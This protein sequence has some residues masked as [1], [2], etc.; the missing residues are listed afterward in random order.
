MKAFSIMA[1]AF[2]RWIDSV[3]QAVL[4][5]H[6]W[7]APPRVVQLIEG[8]TGTFAV[9]TDGQ[10]ADARSPNGCLRIAEGKI[11]EP[12][13]P[14]IA[15]LLS[16]SRLEL[17]L[18][19]ER[20]LFAPLELPGR[21][22]E[23]L[24]GVVRAQID[25]L[26][27]WSAAEAAFGC[28]RPTQSGG[29]RIAITIAAT[30]RSSI[31]PYI[32][33]TACLGAYSTAVLTSPDHHGMKRIQLLWDER[34]AGVTKQARR[35]RLAVVMLLASAGT[36][37]ILAV[38]ASIVVKPILE[39]REKALLRQVSETGAS[40]GGSRP[41]A[42][43]S[44]AAAWRILEHRKN[45]HPPNVIVLEEL[46]QLLPDQTYVTELTIED[47]KLRISGMTQNA[48]SLVGV[49]EQSGR[50]TQATFFAP[51]TKS[52]SDPG[53]RFNIEAHIQSMKSPHS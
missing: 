50:F 3:A 4:T 32:Q 42:A 25:R 51:T 7:L 31:M 27:P 13:P 6:G 21:A 37:A 52:P 16:G 34:A 45:D 19:S 24:D 40:E 29:E 46:S 47:D 48:P 23:F 39:A 22:A 14:D 38:G 10:S 30:A 11:I 5:L 9:R 44:A 2:S 28:S 49:F 43:G 33:A 20:F 1:D 12:P 26:T 53:E 36:A 15:Q 18:R 35:L 8:E 17:I 41:V